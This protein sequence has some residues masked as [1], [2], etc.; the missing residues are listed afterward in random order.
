MDS[1][2]LT[3]TVIKK[4]EKLYILETILKVKGGCLTTV[5]ASASI[6]SAS[7]LDTSGGVLLG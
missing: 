4:V 6:L 1:L 3:Q 5:F 7:A 2:K